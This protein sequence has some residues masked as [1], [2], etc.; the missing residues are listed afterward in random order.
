M[1]LVVAWYSTFKTRASSMVGSGAC[2]SENCLRTSGDSSR[3]TDIALRATFASLWV[4]KGMSRILFNDAR[5]RR[6]RCL[7]RFRRE[8]EDVLQGAREVQIGGSGSSHDDGQSNMPASLN[9]STRL[10][11]RNAHSIQKLGGVST[12]CSAGRQVKRI[13]V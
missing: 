3:S 12:S 1:R 6:G 11:V 2:T 4:G 10:R 7:R 13:R 8:K 5:V 9:S